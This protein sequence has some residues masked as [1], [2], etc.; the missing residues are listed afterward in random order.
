M[1]QHAH[2]IE[3]PATLERAVGLH[4][5]FRPEERY[6]APDAT[7]SVAELGRLADDLTRRRRRRPALLRLAARGLRLSFL[8]PSRWDEPGSKF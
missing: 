5:T 6:V 7:A 1:E 4:A 8:R 2:V 3:D